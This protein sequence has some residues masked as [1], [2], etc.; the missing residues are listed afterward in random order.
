MAVDYKE[1]FE[2]L[3][4]CVADMDHTH[5]PVEISA[6]TMWLHVLD[7]A[8]VKNPKP[9]KTVA[10]LEAEISGRDNERRQIQAEIDVWYS[11]MRQII[12]L[13]ETTANGML[14]RLGEEKERP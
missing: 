10:E 1:R 14:A 6:R 2:E 9:E 11:D 8:S 4:G 13:L 5:P 12:M 3:A 7:A